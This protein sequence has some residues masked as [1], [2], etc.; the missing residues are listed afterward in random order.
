METLIFRSDNLEELEA[1]K[2]IARVLKISFETE[3][4]PYDPEFVAK[5]Q[6]KR[7][8]FEAGDFEEIS[9]EDLSDYLMVKEMDA[10]K[11]DETI[12]HDEFYRQ[13]GWK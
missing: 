9:V 2:A 3:D 1:L 7:K 8:Q 6:E 4:K 13:M 12:S 11:D 10:R 5:I